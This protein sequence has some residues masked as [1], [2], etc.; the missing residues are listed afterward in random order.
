MSVKK[1]VLVIVMVSALLLAVGVG[2]SVGNPARALPESSAEPAR[3]TIPYAGRLS[4]EAGKPVADGAYDFTFTL[5]G[6]V[7]GGEP[8]WS[9]VQRG[10][11]VS[12]GEFLTSLGSVEPIPATALSGQNLWLAVSVRGPS[13]A[14]FTSLA[15]RQRVSAAAPTGRSAACPHDHL[16]ELWIGDSGA[17]IDGLFVQNTR[18][19]GTGV[20]GKS[21]TGDGLVGESGDL[22]KSGV[23]G[24]NTGGGYGVA[25]R[26]TCGTGVK[27]ESANGYWRL[28]PQRQQPQHLRRRLRQR[29][30][31]HLLSRH[32]RGL[33]AFRY[34]TPVWRSIRQA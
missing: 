13:E 17:A 7:S 1:R 20:A 16:G 14:G 8:L 12:K 28:C 11:V 23:Y 4:D 24:N 9:E 5:Y 30:S 19:G 34:L 31:L 2:P 29:R 33:R 10:V 27:G 18:A 6:A 26:S 15:P 25:G 3:G 21:D 22:N 32:E